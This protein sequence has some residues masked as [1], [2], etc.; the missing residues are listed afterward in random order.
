MRHF[1]FV[2]ALVL[3]TAG[4]AGAQDIKQNRGV[5]IRVDYADLTKLGPW[6][7]RNYDLTLEDLAVL[8]D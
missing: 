5:D 3:L 4:L 7:D 1:T 2:L 6:D 8:P